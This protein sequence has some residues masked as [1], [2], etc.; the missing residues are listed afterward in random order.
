MD[1]GFR[2]I[3]NHTH[4]IQKHQTFEERLDSCFMNYYKCMISPITE[5]EYSLEQQCV[6]SV[7]EDFDINIKINANYPDC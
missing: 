3:K 5:K 6:N 1:N 4:L 2:N 7:M